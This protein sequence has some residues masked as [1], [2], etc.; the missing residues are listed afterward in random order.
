MRIRKLRKRLKD[1]KFLEKMYNKLT[2]ESDNLNRFRMFECDSLF[3]GYERAEY[4][5]II[6]DKKNKKLS[7]QIRFIKRLLYTTS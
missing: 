2:I 5:R 4:N 6:Y 3:T 1:R 7:R